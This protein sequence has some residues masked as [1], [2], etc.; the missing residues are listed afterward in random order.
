VIE[1]TKKLAVENRV[2]VAFA[3]TQIPGSGVLGTRRVFVLQKLAAWTRREKK[4]AV[5][6]DVR[7]AASVV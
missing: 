7:V 4:N 1:N 3:G 2:I 6:I 5:Q